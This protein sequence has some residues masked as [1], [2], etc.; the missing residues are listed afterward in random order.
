MRTFFS[1]HGKISFEMVGRSEKGRE[2]ESG[3]F[4]IFRNGSNDIEAFA[5]AGFESH[6]HHHTRREKGREQVTQTVMG[7]DSP[8]V[9]DRLFGKIGDEPRRIVALG[10]RNG[11]GEM[12][13]A[14]ILFEQPGLSE[15]PPLRAV[16][17]RIEARA[18]ELLH[19][20]ETATEGFG[21]E[22]YVTVFSPV[23]DE[24]G[25]YVRGHLIRRIA[26]KARKTKVDTVS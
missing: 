3:A 10:K 24:F 25:P 2:I 16:E 13:K 14:F 19:R 17:E 12:T 15:I 20:L 1:E 23:V 9:G 6:G 21:H 26:S 18:C 22:E 11:G 4:E 7:F 8:G 5:L